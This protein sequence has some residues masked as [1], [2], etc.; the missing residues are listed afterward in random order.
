MLDTH[1]FLWAITD[2]RRLTRQARRILETAD[3]FLSVASIWEIITKMQIGKLP[4]PDAPSKYLPRHVA[5][6][7]AKLL[8][9]ET[10]HILRLE[11]L[12]LHHRDPFD[13]LLVAQS[14][15]EKLPLLSADTLLD[16]YG[17]DIR[18]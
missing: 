13:R 7:G 2:D 16:P 11:A 14:L 1:A 12:P 8:A 3:L 9:I 10:A 15:E 4:L 5:A 6:L 18:W 17:A